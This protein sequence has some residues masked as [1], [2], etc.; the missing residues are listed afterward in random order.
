[1][2]NGTVLDVAVGLIF[3]FLMLSVACS[4]VNERIQ[5]WLDTRA[6]M[7][8]DS[9]VQMLG[10]QSDSVMQH[11]LVQALTY[12]KKKTGMPSYIPSAT[13]AVA[14]FETLVPAGGDYPLTFKR[15]QDAVMKL[16]ASSTARA[17]LL[18]LLNSAQGD[19]NA[20]RAHVEHWFDSAM[21]RLSG[22]YKRHINVWLLL[23]GFALAAGTNADTIQLIQ[24]LE[25][26]TALRTAVEAQAKSVALKNQPTP[27][28]PA[29]G[30]ESDAATLKVTISQAQLD[31]LDL[32]FWDGVVTAADVADHPRAFRQLEWSC[33]WLGWLL[34][35]ILGWAMTA[36]AVSLGAPFWFDLL[37]RLVNLR[38]TG[39]RP[40]K[41]AAA[42]PAA[43]S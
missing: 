4:L 9:L 36:L 15:L 25:H 20:A 21:E 43:S 33:S 41:S 35:K 37:G 39:A 5:S 13:F 10:Y 7:L 6:K 42:A 1:M 29:S 3:V 18:T 32:L 24:R 28:Q 14:L 2:L 30:G 31:K 11:S 40:L 22:A 8:N 38:A 26:E 23:L 19:L 17:S 12:A 34:L 27:S 16:P